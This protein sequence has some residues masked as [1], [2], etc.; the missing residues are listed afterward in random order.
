MQ[1][2]AA[3]KTSSS[4]EL[5]AIEAP[6]PPKKGAGSKSKSSRSVPSDSHAPGTRSKKSRVKSTTSNQ[7]SAPTSASD[8][9]VGHRTPQAVKENGEVGAS[10]TPPSVHQLPSPVPRS[11]VREK[12][13]QKAPI[14]GVGLTRDKSQ[15]VQL[16]QSAKRVKPTRPGKG[17][18]SSS[19][20][21][22]GSS[23]TAAGGK[24]TSQTAAARV[25]TEVSG[26]ASGPASGQLMGSPNVSPPQSTVNPA[27]PLS[28]SSADTM[29]LYDALAAA[30][31]DPC[32]AS[33]QDP[34]SQIECT[35]AEAGKVLS[36]G[37][38]SVEALDIVGMQRTPENA[39]RSARRLFCREE[40]ILAMALA[41]TLFLVLAVVLIVIQSD[42]R[43][44]SKIL[45][46]TEDCRL[47][48][49]LLNDA[50]NRS[51]D[52]CEDFRAHV[53][54]KW[55]PPKGRTQLRDFDT[56]T[57]HDMV[58]S[59]LFG[60]RTTLQ[61]GSAL[62]PV[63][64]KALAMFESCMSNLS[65][66]GSTLHE[67]R[68]F[69]ER[70][71]IPWPEASP[72]DSDALRVL[73]TLAY[74]WQVA[75][76][77]S[78][79]AVMKHGKWNILLTAAPRLPFY[80]H[81]HRSVK[82][83]GSYAAYW[84]QY[85]RAFIG[86]VKADSEQR[87]I[88]AQRLEGEILEA[89]NAAL[90][91]S[92]KDASVFPI[93]EVEVYTQSI[94][95]SRWLRALQHATALRPEL[96]EQDEMVVNNK[97]FLLTIGE[98]L[99]NYT[100]AQILEF[101]AWQFVQH[102]APV[103]DSRLLLTRYGDQQKVDLL[104]PAFCGLHIEVAYKVLLLTLYFSS[105]VTQTDRRLV[106]GAF[107]RLLSTTI[108]LVNSTEWLDTESK[109]VVSAKIGS[110]YMRLWPPAHFLTNENLEHLYE[111][112]PGNASSFGFYWLESIQSMRATNRTPEY[113]A[114]LDL[115]LNYAQPYLEYDYVENSVDVAIGAVARPLFYGKGT[116][117]MLYGG[118]GFSVAV[119]LVK[120][121]DREGLHWRPGGE[122][123]T[124]IFSAP[125]QAAFEEKEQCAK[126]TTGGASHSLFP[127]IPALQ[128][129]YSAFLGATNEVGSTPPISEELTEAK[130]FFITL[131]YMT[132]SLARVKNA[133]AANCNQVV[134]N[135]LAFA[136]VFECP[137]GSKMNPI[138]KCN[139]FD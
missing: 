110:V 16:V 32:L 45:C 47:H 73:V 28:L 115:P 5:V 85:Y 26:G 29:R 129:A 21:K 68:T 138:K 116:K 105:R 131:C 2:E 117:G 3:A 108:S 106:D 95:T 137:P 67:F 15:P 107:E 14:N 125:S 33:P 128:V 100:N 98:L 72:T 74:N 53:C 70:R 93:G 59:W 97:H 119:E 56:S 11:S 77:F 54:S 124:S 57:M 49:F 82:I 42:S 130:V 39:F 75:L 90:E 121:I 61:D 92:P 78:L 24:S 13:L 10:A 79:R 87:A 135:S 136:N 103:A 112:F 76:W 58:Y 1:I 41:V 133:F 122:L 55:S 71:D 63:G 60:I 111:P 62:F 114:V 38:F 127:E 50:L 25:S 44:R 94:E 12:S 101:L 104:R 22:P 113:E 46:T 102:Y 52:A 40:L 30:N 51:I 31:P 7:A 34:R 80:L 23:G 139:F 123:T 18:R 4:K 64:L 36:P 84:T 65:E 118:L 17:D 66:Y 132:C 19:Q 37:V 89:L 99:G 35:E 9:T 69:L 134:R 43:R 120:A 83:A 126:T 86:D 20:R 48:A 27:S 109:A 91:A 6:Q 81:Y 96:T 88:E 8:S